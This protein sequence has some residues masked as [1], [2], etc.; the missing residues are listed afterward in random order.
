MKAILILALCLPFLGYGQTVYNANFQA[1]DFS[2]NPTVPVSGSAGGVNAKYLYTNVITIDGQV[3][4]A[5]V[6]I[7]AKDPG[8]TINSVDKTIQLANNFESDITIGNT[9]PLSDGGVTF[10]FEFIKGGTVAAPEAVILQNMMMNSYDIDGNGG[11]YQYQEFGGFSMYTVSSTTTLKA[12]VQSNGMTRFQGNGVNATSGGN[13]ITLGDNWRIRATFNAMSSF[14]TKIGGQSNGSQAFFSMLFAGGS[15]FAA[16]INLVNPT[17]NPKTSST[18]TTTVT[19]SYELGSDVARSVTITS[20]SVVI[21]G[22]T[23]TTANGLSFLNG[24]W[25]VNTQSIPNGTYNVYTSVSY[26]NNYTLIDQTTNELV[27]SNSTPADNTAPIILAIKRSNPTKQ[28]I[29][30]PEITVQNYVDFEVVFS[31]AVQAVTADDYSVSGPGGYQ[32]V[33]STITPVSSSKY[34]VKVSSISV[35]NT[36]DLN[37]NLEAANNVADLAGNLLSN[38]EPAIHEYYILTTGALS[39]QSIQ[40]MGSKN[41]GRME[42]KWKYHGG[43]RDHSFVVESSENGISWDEFAQVNRSSGDQYFL[44]TVSAS[45]STQ[46]YRIRLKTIDGLQLFSNVIRLESSAIN[47]DFRILGNPVNRAIIKVLIYKPGIYRLVDATGVIRY[48]AALNAGQH[49]ITPVFVSGGIYFFGTGE[50]MQQLVVE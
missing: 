18:N 25:T 30:Y 29:G 31:E 5:L 33:I 47:A 15:S 48:S 45:S 20:F 32:T 28:F 42:L 46:Y 39:V 17:V 22:V 50:L 13:N 8:I 19:G 40:L 41:N 2:D 26:S 7:V 34:L 36:G 38:L 12:T 44:S 6:T 3:I 10:R 23:Y 1:L 49:Q 21:N 43:P 9:S 4:D 35:A 24:I 37:L 11:K 16:G 27:I 14:T